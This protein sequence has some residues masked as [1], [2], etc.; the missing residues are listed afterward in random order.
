MCSFLCDTLFLTQV[1]LEVHCPFEVPSHY[2][3]ILYIL[4]DLFCHDANPTQKI[5]P[6]RR[7]FESEIR[8]HK[9]LY[10]PLPPRTWIVNLKT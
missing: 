8:G 1:S 3:M 6:L 5:L 10:I 7:F 9:S 4:F 2:P